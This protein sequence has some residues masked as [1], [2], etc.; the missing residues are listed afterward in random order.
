MGQTV[1]SYTTRDALS[2]L[3]QFN[4]DPDLKE[5]PPR[6]KNSVAFSFDGLSNTLNGVTNSLFLRTMFSRPHA[7]DLLEMMDYTMSGK[8][9]ATVPMTV[10]VPSAATAGGDL[11]ID[12][13]DLV[14]ETEG[15]ATNA[16][17]RFEARSDLTI[18]QGFT[19]G[20]VEAFQQTTRPATDLGQTD[21]TEFQR[22][23]TADL[24]VIKDTI[25]LTIA[26]DTYTVVDSWR[27]SFATDL[28]FRLFHRS[29]GSSFVKLP[30]ANLQDGEAFGKKPLTALSI[31]ANYA[32][33]GG[34]RGNQAAGRI[35]KYVGGDVNVTDV[36][37][38]S[39]STGGTAEE[40][41]ENAREIAGIS[42]RG[43]EIASN[44]SV[45]LA[46][47]KSVSGVLTASFVNTGLFR[48]DAFI[49][50]TGGGL[51]ST[52][53]KTEV[54]DLLTE[55]SPLGQIEVTGRDPNYL[56]QAIAGEVQVLS[57]FLF[58]NIKHLV[59]LAAA[60]RTS[61]IGS[62]INNTFL[63]DGLTA[64]I[65]QING[66][67][68]SSGLVSQTIVEKDDGP[69]VERFLTN[70]PFQSFGETLH[71]EDIISAVQGFVTGVDV[72]KMLNPLSDI[73]VAPGFIVRPVSNTWTA[74]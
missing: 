66:T 11:L 56:D 27:D 23:D 38:P 12:Q 45:F 14:F 48:V 24:D 72:A 43:T 74:F 44:Q 17:V 1:I 18:S 6:V 32:V 50:P 64:A 60:L 52:A 30:G 73:T 25:T 29:D 15:T 41:I 7:Q 21:G 8:G 55:K 58:S 2:I 70:I 69:Q 10:T 47:A 36:T 35:I 49:I 4:A 57:G 5:Q 46:L 61:E 22:V 19:T 20:T 53:L 34:S 62:E 39:P 26:A 59:E 31:I 13:A 33:G 71:P 42:L 9:V 16:P 63:T 65:A 68:V 3:A 54:G 28:H 40:S 37:N 67:F 51:P